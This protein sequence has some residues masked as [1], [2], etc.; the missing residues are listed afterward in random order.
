[1]EGGHALADVLF[2][3]VDP[4]G[5][6]PTTF[7][8]RLEDSPAYA[9]YPGQD[10]VV[11]YDEGMFVGYRHYDRHDVEPRF[12]FGHGLSYTRFA[13]TNLRVESQADHVRAVVDLTNVGPRA[14]RDVV[15][16]YVRDVNAPADQPQKELRDFAKVDLQPGETRSVTF[17]LPPRAFA[18]WNTERGEWQV[19]T[20]EREILVGASSRDIRARGAC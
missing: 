11:R 12:C 14:G 7:P 1:M 5:R 15:Q 16:V 10:G 13:Y 8:R 19:T 18:H 6:L 2:G 9:N 17:D 3:D 20:A 4:S